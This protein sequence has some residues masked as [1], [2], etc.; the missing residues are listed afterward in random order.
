MSYSPYPYEQLGS[1]R[2]TFY[3]IGIKHIEKVVDFIP[4]GIRNII[5][6]GFGDL[7]PDGTVDDKVNS[8]NGD[9]IKVLA[10]VIE[11]LKEYTSDHPNTIIHFEGSTKE[12]TRLYTR[13]LKTYYSIFSKEFILLAFV[14][15]K[16]REHVVTFDPTTNTEYSAFLIKRIV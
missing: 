9:L 7:R 2:Y 4:V 10:T 5:N 13:I 14:Q 8:N 12:R 3:S 11:I 15:G 1:E 6:L 16:E